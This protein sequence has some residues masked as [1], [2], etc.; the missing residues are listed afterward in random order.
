MHDSLSQFASDFC[1]AIS[2]GS[3]VFHSAVTGRGDS[4]FGRWALRLWRLQLEENPALASDLRGRGVDPERVQDWREIPPMPA[5]AFKELELSSIPPLRRTRVFHSSGTT[6]QVPS[7]HFHCPESL[8]VYEASLR[9]W[10]RRHLLPESLGGPGDPGP[11]VLSLT[12]A[13]K[14]APHS[15][16]AYMLDVVVR[17]TAPGGN[18]EGPFF[19]SLDSEGAWTVE[20]N[21]L[22]EALEG[23]SE[24]GVCVLLAGTAFNFV[25]LIDRLDATG[26][27]LVLP[28]GS[29]IM[30]TGGYKGRSRVLARPELHAALTDRLGIPPEWIVGEYG[31]SELSSQAYD[32]IAGTGGV[33]CLRFPP[34][35]RAVVISPEHGREVGEGETGLV[36]ILDLAN[37]WSV[38]CL[39]TADLALRRGDG[40]ELVGRLAGAEPRGCSLH[41]VGGS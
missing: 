41:S 14:A 23:A 8:Q 26:C 40:I 32:T 19:G 17:N 37:V 28:K 22:V 9:P 34:W 16:L 25:H 2:G 11:R 33:R 6:G 39:Q 10:F 4:E 35:A 18:V 31:M 1:A 13:P 21:R 7:R 20:A 29:R 3:E 27:R 5:A 38:L 30:E 12:P 15:S 36:R 24:A